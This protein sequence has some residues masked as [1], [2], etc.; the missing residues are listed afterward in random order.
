MLP[1]ATVAQAPLTVLPEPRFSRAANT[2]PVAIKLPAVRTLPVT[3]KLPLMVC[4]A[5]QKL[6]RVRS[7]DNVVVPPKLVTPPPLRPAPATTVTLVIEL[8]NLLLVMAPSATVCAIS[9]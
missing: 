2:S 4:G 5:A 3:V 7:R 6:V 1:P 9:A 8:A